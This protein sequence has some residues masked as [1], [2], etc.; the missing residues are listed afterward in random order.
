MLNV[1]MQSVIMVSGVAPQNEKKI[2]PFCSISFTS[3]MS[4]FG[5]VPVMNLIPEHC[6]AFVHNSNLKMKLKLQNYGIAI[7]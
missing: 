5:F 6:N 1:I 7:T 3:F 2:V 4:D